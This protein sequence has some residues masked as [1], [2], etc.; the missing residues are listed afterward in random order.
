MTGA[1]SSRRTSVSRR[2]LAVGA[3]LVAATTSLSAST[4]EV[5]RWR[6]TQGDLRVTCPLTVGGSFEART[7]ALT[8]TLS[9]AGTEPPSFD[10]A[11]SVDLRQ[12]TTGID[13][14]D[15]HMRDSYLETGKGAAYEAAV[16]SA[17]RLGKGTIETAQ[18]RLPFAGTLTLH[19]V[20]RQL[21]GEAE[22]RRDGSNVRISAS[23]PIALSDFG[24]P[25]P[26]YLGVGVKNEVQVK[27][28]LTASPDTAGAPR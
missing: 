24:I 28:A 23:F 13:L 16:L 15:R 9:L 3:A 25:K 1:H 11:I 18:G 8:G 12:L 10:G 14:R 21:A 4:A 7:S 17:L 19:G 2:S 26:Q 5:P 27:V 6:T 22:V 20:E